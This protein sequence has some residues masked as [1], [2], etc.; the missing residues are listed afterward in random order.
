MKKDPS[1]VALFIYISLGATNLLVS[2]HSVLI[3]SKESW[4]LVPLS[5]AC[6]FLMCWLG[7]SGLRKRARRK[8]Q[9]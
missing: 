9:R 3:P 2:L 8:E 4:F 7:V 6:A 1:T 5:L